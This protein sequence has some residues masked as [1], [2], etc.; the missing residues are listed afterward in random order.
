MSSNLENTLTLRSYRTFRSSLGLIVVG[1]FLLTTAGRTM[2]IMCS[3]TDNQCRVV[4]ERVLQSNDQEI[5]I[6]LEEVQAARVIRQQHE[7]NALH[8]TV[9]ETDDG[10][11]N[12]SG[13]SSMWRSTHDRAARQINQFLDNPERQ[14]LDR[15]F[16]WLQPYFFSSPILLGL[17]LPFL[18]RPVIEAMVDPLHRT[19]KLRRRRWW[20]EAGIDTSIPLDEIQDVDVHVYVD[21]MGK[22]RRTKYITIIVLKSGETVRLFQLSKK[23][24]FNHAEQLKQHLGGFLTQ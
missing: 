20:Q 7:N 16:G 9:L 2:R 6:P 4:Q 5:V 21:D 22:R 11:I 3:R 24:A 8:R 10:S 17:V 23:G 1:V 19:L 15:R 12:L 18:V 14:S 13:Y